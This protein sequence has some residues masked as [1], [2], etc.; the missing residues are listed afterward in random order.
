MVSESKIQEFS[1]RLAPLKLIHLDGRKNLF[2]FLIKK[3]LKLVSFVL[4]V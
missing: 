3:R 4:V 1:N 2:V